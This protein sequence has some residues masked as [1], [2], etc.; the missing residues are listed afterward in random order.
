MILK[1]FSQSVSLPSSNYMCVG[2]V[3]PFRTPAYLRVN[4]S[5]LCHPSPCTEDNLSIIDYR[6]DFGN[7]MSGTCLDTNHRVSNFPRGI[8]SL[9]LPLIV[10][11]FINKNQCFGSGISILRLIKSASRCFSH[12]CLVVGLQ[13]TKRI[14]MIT[15]WILQHAMMHHQDQV[16][17]IVVLVTPRILRKLRFSRLKTL[18]SSASFNFFR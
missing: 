6:D 15:F 10:W 12:F 14:I 1:H 7:C 4:T 16:F 17:T 8:F 9:Q 13:S 18:T 5:R 3:L 11:E 2:S